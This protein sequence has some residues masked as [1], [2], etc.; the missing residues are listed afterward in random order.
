MEDGAGVEGFHGGLAGARVG[1][2]FGSGG[3]AGEVLHCEGRLLF[4]ELRGDVAHGRFDSGVEAGLARGKGVIY[5]VPEIALTHLGGGVGEE[6]QQ[7]QPVTT[8][9]GAEW[10]ATGKVTVKV[11]RDFPTATAASVRK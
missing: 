7:P 9:R 5:L 10:A 6:P 11:P 2:P 1:P 3:E 8:Q 4:E